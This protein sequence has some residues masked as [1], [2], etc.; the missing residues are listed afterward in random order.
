MKL[1]A[2]SVVYGL[3]C[4]GSDP[5]F[6]KW[7]SIAARVRGVLLGLCTHDLLPRAWGKEFHQE[8]QAA[9][10]E[11]SA[12]DAADAAPA[13]QR[14]AQREDRTRFRKVAQF[15]NT[16]AVSYTHLRAHETS[17]HL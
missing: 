4:T 9:L 1:A 8:L 5:T 17:A 6:V 14:D 7:F 13:E 10:R 11:A 3:L 2:E 12:D 15:L 16:E